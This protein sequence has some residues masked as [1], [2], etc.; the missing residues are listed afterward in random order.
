VG[1]EGTPTVTLLTVGVIA[2]MLLIVYRS[3][4]T[5]GVVFGHRLDHELRFR[6]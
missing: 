2:V 4:V 5:P 3:P 6:K 1:N